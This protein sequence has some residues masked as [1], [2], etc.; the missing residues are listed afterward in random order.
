MDLR[1]GLLLVGLILLVFI[2]VYSRYKREI[3]SF[4]VAFA[5]L[6]TPVTTTI[7][8]AVGVDPLVDDSLNEPKKVLDDEPVPLVSD[9]PVA[10]IVAIRMMSVAEGGF[11]A[12]KLILALRDAGLRHGKFG[13]FH[14]SDEDNENRSDFS[15]ASLIEP[16]SFDLTRVKK[17]F[18]PGVSIFLRLPGPENELNAFDDMLQ[19]SKSLAVKL[20]AELL[21]EQGSTLSI[22]RE[23]YMREE[24]IQ[25]QHQGK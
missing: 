19:T 1:W 5:K 2:Y 20:D 24:V 6:G 15:V 4:F 10:K 8:T 22:Q 7:E 25:F 14:R 12:E 16:G 13:I 9:L 23:R 17:D 3:D 21:D 11:S 18:Y